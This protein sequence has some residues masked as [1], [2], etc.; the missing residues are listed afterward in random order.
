MHTLPLATGVHG[1]KLP[2]IGS[3]LEWVEGYGKSE[4]VESE[5][6]NARIIQAYLV[7]VGI[8]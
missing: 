3:Y 6:E 5:A 2:I 4:I 1:F 8:R 7:T